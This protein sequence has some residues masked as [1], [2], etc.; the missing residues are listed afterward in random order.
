MKRE[1]LVWQF[2]VLVGI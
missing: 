1:K 2:H